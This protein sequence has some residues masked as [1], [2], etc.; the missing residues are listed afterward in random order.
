MTIMHFLIWQNRPLHFL[1]QN[2]PLYITAKVN[3][4]S[5][6]GEKCVLL[7][8]RNSRGEFICPSICRSRPFPRSNYR[9]R[10]CVKSTATAVRS[11]NL[12]APADASS[13]CKNG[14]TLQEEGEEE[15]AH[16]VRM[17]CFAGEIV[18]ESG[19]AMVGMPASCNSEG[20][21]ALAFW[22]CLGVH[23]SLW[24]SILSVSLS[25]F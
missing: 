9:R 23:P 13:G 18:G 11:G 2:R 1:W 3:R 10:C 22:N 15:E 8:A 17:L 14:F 6:Y 4:L 24:V 21:A 7:G 5:Y 12:Q 16:G 20:L 19:S 25:V